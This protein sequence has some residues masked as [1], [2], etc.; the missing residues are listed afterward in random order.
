MP[1]KKIKPFV[2][3]AGG[4][5]QLIKNLDSHFPDFE[6]TYYEPFLGGGAIF[7]HLRP[8]K[9]IL[10]DS[11]EELINLFQII[12]DK[13]QKLM[14]RLDSHQTKV[15]D[16]EYYLDVRSWDMRGIFYMLEDAGLL[17]SHS[18][19]TVFYDRKRW[20][21]FFWTLKGIQSIRMPRWLRVIS[22]SHLGQE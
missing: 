10:G 14:E 21:L 19:E 18:E 6:G 8:E 7:F 16:K 4:K 11:N 9:A 15:Q 2:K 17:T 12:K 22:L 1:M 13:P 5:T 3:W 20:T